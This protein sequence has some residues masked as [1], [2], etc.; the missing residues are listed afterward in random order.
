ML[1]KSSDIYEATP[2]RGCPPNKLQTTQLLCQHT[3]IC[4]EMCHVNQALAQ[5]LN[6]D[7]RYDFSKPGTSL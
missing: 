1:N 2:P 3:Q 6:K 5:T 7:I 4:V